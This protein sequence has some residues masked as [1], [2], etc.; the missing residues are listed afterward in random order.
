[1]QIVSVEDAGG[2]VTA[3]FTVHDAAGRPLP[4]LGASDVSLRIDG[5]AVA[6]DSVTG[7]VA[8]QLGIAVVLAIDTSG[9]MAG[10]PLAAAADASARFLDQLSAQDSVAL[11]T[12]ADRATVTQPLTQ[13]LDRLRARLAELRATGATA[14]Y[15]AVGAAVGVAGTAPHPRRAI[16]VLSDGQ[17]S[18]A[19]AAARAAAL[20]RARAGGALVY[21]IGLG[22]TTDRD[23][24]QQLAATTGGRFLIAPGPTDLQA[25]FGELGAALRSQ[26]VLVAASPPGG[27]APHEL[28]VTVTRQGGSGRARASFHSTTP[29]SPAPVPSPL[30]AARAPEQPAGVPALA[31]AA[32][33]GAV[34]ALAATAAWRFTHRRARAIPVAARP[35]A[36]PSLAPPPRRARRALLTVIT[37]TD[38]GRTLEVRAGVTTLT[39]APDGALL[40]LEPTAHGAHQLRV[41]WRDNQLMAHRP[42][43]PPERAWSSL[44]DG[45]TLDLGAERLSVRIVDA[46]PTHAAPP[47]RDGPPDDLHARP[48]DTRDAAAARSSR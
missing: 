21:V 22:A 24:L 2:R 15:D 9:S 41:W 5:R 40:E 12:F 23:F 44:R 4:A 30:A 28:E 36:L 46:T 20:D 42:G 48:A 43:E 18:A 33:A 8:A 39:A 11:V 7:A 37:G 32:S 29:A 19:A 45:D 47:P 27:P 17:D 3:V 10:P 25:A 31:L 14:L 35:L 38:A 6:V 13:D 1:V 26:Q 34:L 16:V